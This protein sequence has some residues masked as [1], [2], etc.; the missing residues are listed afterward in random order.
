MAVL[1]A[2][3]VISLFA[4]FG[5]YAAVRFFCTLLLAPKCLTVALEVKEPVGAEEAALLLCR[6]RECAIAPHYRTVVLVGEEMERR[7][8][9]KMHFAR[10]GAVCYIVKKE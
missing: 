3:I 1:I 9:V 6:A 10:L 2:E 8:E 4:V 5:L 7:D